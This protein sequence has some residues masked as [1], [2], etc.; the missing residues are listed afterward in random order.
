MKAHG[1]GAS[2]FSDWW[3]YKAEVKDAIPYNAALMHEQGIVVAINSDDAEMGARLNQEAGKIVKYGG[4]PAEEALKMVTL[5]PAKLLHLDDRMGSL[6]VGKDAD[7]VVWNNEPLSI[8]ARAEKTYIDGT[9]YFSLEE[10]EKA[11]DAFAA[12]RERIIQKMEA[13]KNGGASTRKPQ[14]KTPYHFHCDSMD[15]TSKGIFIKE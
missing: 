8:Y 4:V 9:C 1:A 2:T 3:A 6:K 14:P 15:E 13:A 12:E 5:N 10:D 7:F 11:R